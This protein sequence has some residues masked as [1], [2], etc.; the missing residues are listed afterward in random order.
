M[1]KI[2]ILISMLIMSVMLAVS[3]NAVLT[4][5]IQVPS[6]IT[7]YESEITPI[8]PTFKP[9]NATNKSFTIKGSDY[10][11]SYKAFNLGGL[12]GTRTEKMTCKFSEYISITDNNSLVGRKPTVETKNN[13]KEFY[14]EVTITANDGSGAT[15]TMLVNVKPYRHNN[16]SFSGKEATCTESGYKGGLKCSICGITISGGETI[17]A[18]GHKFSD[19]Y[20]VDIAATC[21]T[22]G[23]KS[24]H[25]YYCTEVKDST[26]I[27]KTGHN[28]TAVINNAT[29]TQDGQKVNVCVCGDNYIVEIIPAKGHTMNG[30]ECEDCEYKVDLDCSCKCHKKGIVGFFWKIRNFFNKLFKKNPICT[31]GA[32]H[33]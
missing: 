1:R 13:N 15:A 6:V 2:V 33:Y 4:T 5:S 25:C 12:L 11:Y 22:A 21:T 32:I 10:T 19:N 23:V 31:C 16:V 7:I 29:C 3:A 24:R 8:N 27:P 28:Y 14:F 17:P 9:E 26:T 18:R 20:T 30:M